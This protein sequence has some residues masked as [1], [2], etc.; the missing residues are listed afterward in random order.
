MERFRQ[1]NVLECL[2]SAGESLVAMRAAVS[3][4]LR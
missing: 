3:S 2:S 4:R 1:M